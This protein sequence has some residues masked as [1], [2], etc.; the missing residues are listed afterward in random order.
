[1]GNIDLWEE[2]GEAYV[3]NRGEKP[4]WTLPLASKDENDLKLVHR[5]LMGEVE[6]LKHVNRERFSLCHKN[7]ALYKGIQYRDQELRQGNRERIDDKTRAVEKIVLNHLFDLSKSRISKLLKYKPAVA[8]MP[9]NDEWEDQV[10]AKMTK[11]WLD[12]IWY[13]ERFDGVVMPKFVRY[14]QP[15]GE[16]YLFIDW[17]PDKGDIAKQYKEAM[18]FA[19]AQGNERVPLM[20]EDGNQELDDNGNPI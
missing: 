1:M 17:D 19:Q 2:A 8:I 13:V 7:L 3:D 16:A 20:D 6:Y 14:I 4:F 11:F 18:Q 5:W 15:M 9:T 10:S 12:H